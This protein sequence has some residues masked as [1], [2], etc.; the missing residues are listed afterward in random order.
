MLFRARVAEDPL[1]GLSLGGLDVILAGHLA[2]A[3]PIGDDPLYKPGAYKGKGLNKPP[4]NYRG[5]EPKTLAEFVSD[6]RLFV[7]EFDDVA[8]LLNTHRV[9]ENGDETWSAERREAYKANAQKFLEVTRR[10][11]DLE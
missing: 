1:S 8:M 6:A 3:A 11:A 9:D 10:M 2:Q 7:Q 5:P 4:D